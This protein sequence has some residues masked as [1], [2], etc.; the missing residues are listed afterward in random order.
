[1]QDSGTRF[2]D[3]AKTEKEEAAGD[4]RRIISQEKTTIHK[5]KRIHNVVLLHLFIKTLRRKSK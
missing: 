3:Q 4:W 1:M 5:T 2:T